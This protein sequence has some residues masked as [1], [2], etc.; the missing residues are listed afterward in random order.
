MVSK[1]SV[2]CLMEKGG[3]RLFYNS[4]LGWGTQARAWSF[5]TPPREHPERASMQ[6][7]S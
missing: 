7:S 6:L 2:G 3:E 1:H 4:G 5:H